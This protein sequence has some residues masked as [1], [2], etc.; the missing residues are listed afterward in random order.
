MARKPTY[1]KERK[2]EIL[3]AAAKV[4][5]ERGLCDTR[6]VDVAKQ[7]GA[8][9]A[10]VMY[11]FESK[12]RLLTEAL[13]FTDDRFYSQTFN[14]LTN[15]DT[16][17]EKLTLLIEESCP[18]PRADSELADDWAL[19]IELWSRGLRD[20]EAAKKRAALD[21]RWRWTIADVV[22]S[23]QRSGEFGDVDADEFSLHLASLID[24]LALQVVLEDEEITTERMRE[25]CIDFARRALDVDAKSR[26]EA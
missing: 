3:E 23:G 9:A 6:I 16:A 8:S 11:Y 10:L 25:L 24:G 12:D 14:E 13:T 21:R 20:P 17:R 1:S 4:I 26:M 22:R 15:L 7:A 2:Q 18:T 5:S 19:W